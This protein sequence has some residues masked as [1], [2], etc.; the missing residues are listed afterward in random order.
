MIRNTGVELGKPVTIG[1]NVWIGGNTVINP[2]V[3]KRQFNE[4]AV[5]SKDSLGTMHDMN[6]GINNISI[7]IE[8]SAQGVTN[9]AQEMSLIH[10]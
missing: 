10:I 8:E 5:K 6:E 1:D 3:Y 9:V 4:F 7:A 2:D